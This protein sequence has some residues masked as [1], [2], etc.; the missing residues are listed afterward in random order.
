MCTDSNIRDGYRIRL[1][2]KPRVLSACVQKF[3]S[4]ARSACTFQTVKHCGHTIP[5]Y[6]PQPGFQFFKDFVDGTYSSN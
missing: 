2:G 1:A 5:T 3:V 4:P 6:C